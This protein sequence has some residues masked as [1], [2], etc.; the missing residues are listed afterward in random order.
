MRIVGL[1]ILLWACAPKNVALEPLPPWMTEDG[2]VQVR[3]DLAHALLEGDKTSPAMEIV[4][5]LRNEGIDT[6]EVALIQGIALRKQGLMGE[7]RAVLEE[8][9]GKRPRDP[10]P[11][12]ELAILRADD[13]EL[14]VA[15][16]LL[17]RATEL[18]SDHA[19]TWNNLGFL[20]LSLGQCVEAR[21]ALEKA[22]AADGTEPL[23]RNNLGFSLACDGRDDA[24]LAAFTSTGTRADAHYNLGVAKENQGADAQ[25][26][27]QYELALAADSRHP[28]ARQ[29]VMRLSRPDE[30][31]E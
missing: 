21:S 26:L 8:V 10:R 30:D 13:G 23:Y 28:D 22:L 1:A 19:G 16:A 17:S 25:A 20:R 11:L 12:R 15:V 31:K 14:D 6:P 24:A 9:R 18:D 29:A 27:V 2:R 7:A 5:L 4:R 3:I